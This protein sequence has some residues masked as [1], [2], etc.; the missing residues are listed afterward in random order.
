MSQPMLDTCR[1]IVVRSRSRI[2]CFLWPQ[3]CSLLITGSEVTNGGVTGVVQ[4]NL[5][6]VMEGN[7]KVSVWKS[8]HETGKKPTTGPDLNRSRPEIS[9]T[10]TAV[11]STVHH[12]LK[13]VRTDEKPV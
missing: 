6:K 3:G 8:G 11:R 9:K 10:E 1:Y 13:F 4:S 7:G 5:R 12:N 2:L